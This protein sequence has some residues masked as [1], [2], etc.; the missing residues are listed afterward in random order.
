[1]PLIG[2]ETQTARYTKGMPGHLPAWLHPP[3][4]A[5][6]STGVETRFTN[7]RDPEPRSR[8]VFAFHRPETLADWLPDGSGVSA[9][10][11]WGEGSSVQDS[12]RA[13]IFLSRVRTMP[14]LVTHACDA[15]NRPWH[16]ALS[17]V[18]AR[19]SR[20]DAG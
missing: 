16:R 5:Y 13:S 7:G 17:C 15:A 10:T 14:P 20:F 18:G 1:V 9:E 2:V 11:R 12:P 6:E 19:A 8:G 4:F 3:P